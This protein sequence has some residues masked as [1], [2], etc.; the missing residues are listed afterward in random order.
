[1]YGDRTYIIV[2][3]E[4]GRFLVVRKEEGKEHFI[5]SGEETEAKANSLKELI[6]ERVRAN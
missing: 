5:V 3:T 4:Y 1:M 6:E 2:K